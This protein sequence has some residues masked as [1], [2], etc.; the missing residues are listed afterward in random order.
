MSR[1]EPP[2]ESRE[3]RVRREQP[4]HL[5]VKPTDNGV[6]RAWEGGGRGSGLKE[7]N[8]GKENICHTSNNKHQWAVLGLQ[9]LW[10]GKEGVSATPTWFCLLCHL[11]RELG[12]CTGPVPCVPPR[13]AHVVLQF[14]Y[15][16][17]H[18]PPP[19]FTTSHSG[20]FSSE[21]HVLRGFPSWLGQASKW[22][23]LGGRASS[24]KTPQVTGQAA[25][26][27]GRRVWGT[28]AV[29]PTVRRQ[30]PRTAG[31]GCVRVAE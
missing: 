20:A 30:V 6:G 7:V 3:G 17:R 13:G 4:M 14:L 9:K 12:V 24:E 16:Q 11:P 27:G 5:H 22:G 18:A 8:G 19:A 21:S 29:L 31:M 10:A 28:R 23:F 1:V 15:V 25:G 26:P 2:R